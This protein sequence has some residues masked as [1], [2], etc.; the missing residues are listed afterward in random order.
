MLFVYI[1]VGICCYIH[2]YACT[3]FYNKEACR[4]DGCVAVGFVE[5]GKFVIAAHLYVAVAIGYLERVVGV[6]LVGVNR[7][8][9]VVDGE[10]L[11]EPF[12]IVACEKVLCFTPVGFTMC[13]G[14]GVSMIFVCEVVEINVYCFVVS[15]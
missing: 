11:C 10:S 3:W 7:F 5:D 1:D 2:R 14:V 15:K 4:D 8:F 13:E 12:G 9:G 6:E